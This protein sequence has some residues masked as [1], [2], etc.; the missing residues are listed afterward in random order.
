M[1]NNGE[2]SGSVFF[3]KSKKKWRCAYYTYDNEQ[4]KEVRKYKIFST[5]KAAKDFL[6]TKQYQ[7]E[8]ELYIQNKGIPLTELM[9]A[10]LEKKMN[11]NS[12][13][14]RQYVRI[15]DCIEKIEKCDAF[16]KNIE[17]I[18][19]KEIQDF[20]NTL[21]HY[22]N[23]TISKIYSQF[24]Y[25]YRLAMDKGYIL[26]NP[27]VDVIKPRSEKKTK[28]VRALE[29]D[30]QKILTSYLME[31]PICEERFKNVF[32]LQMYMGMRIGEACALRSTDI[33]LQKNIIT[34]DKTL[35]TDRKNRVI[36]GDSPKTYAGIR[37]IP[38]PLQI[39]DSI[40]EQMRI[41]QTNNNKQLFV[42][43]LGNY[44]NPKNVNRRL[45]KLLKEMGI[46]DISSH[47]LRH[48]YGTRCIEAGMRDVALQRLMGHN[49]ISTTLNTYTSVFS[50]YKETELEKVNNYYM[51]NDIF[52]NVNLQLLEDFK[53]K[54]KTMEEKEIE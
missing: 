48:T 37:D 11:T 28:V 32:L 53:R 12:I 16:H 22:S 29:V 47:S 33:D 15:E 13:S 41:A 20:L 35:T 43:C 50:R 26:R 8:N 23:S 19:S 1:Q 2:K 7:Q 40:I 21:T 42:D 34:V 9:R 30:E 3:D 18:T 4:L 24:S 36:M 31:V 38:I 49:N 14:D 27:M 52:D 51:N 45:K 39:R 10:T 6:K 54:N 17:D 25:N 5:E 44:V 46:E